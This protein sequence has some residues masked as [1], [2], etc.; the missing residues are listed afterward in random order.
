MIK[1]KR[2]QKLFVALTMMLLPLAASAQAT[3]SIE[4]FDIKAGEEKEMVI[5]LTNPNDEI[6]LVQFDLRLPAGLSLKQTGGDY[7]YDMCDRTTWRKHSLD[8][9]AT[10]GIIRFLLASSSNTVIS[11]STGA[12]I[13]MTLTA[14]GSFT[15]GTI[16]LENILLVS[17]DEKE[18]KPSDVEL[19]IGE[20]TP[21]GD[22]KDGDEFTA[23]TI[24]GIDMKFQV[25]SA[26]DKTCQ[27][28]IDDADDGE[29]SYA[30]VDRAIDFWE[31]RG[32]VTIPQTVNGFNVVKISEGAFVGCWYVTSIVIPEGVTTISLDAF[33]DCEG[34]EEINL[35]NSLRYI[36]DE[37]F[38]LCIS[39]K[40]VTIPANCSLGNYLF[41]SCQDLKSIHSYIQSPSDAGNA[42]EPHW[43]D[44]KVYENATL[45][46]PQGTKAKYQAA[47]GWKKFKNIVEEGETPT[48]VPDTSAY[49]SF[50]P[51]NIKAGETKE[52]VIDL[53]NP[54]DEITLV[55]FDLRLPTGLSLK[56]VGSDYDIDM[57]SRTT[58]RKHSLD[59]NET[60]GIIRFLLASSSNTVIDG[61]EGA[62]IKMTLV[63]D[64]SYSGG[65]V[66]LE[67]ILLVTPDE[68][69]IK[70][71][72][73]SGIE[74]IVTIAV[75][76][77]KSSKVYSLS[78]QRLAAPRKGINIVGGKKVLVK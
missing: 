78:G 24:E 60:D 59:A 72:N 48:P 28:G 64:G 3:L 56:K 10:E 37:A 12:I 16:R 5:D 8:V 41:D 14:D 40:N 47:E 45:Y 15:K 51:F 44:I 46:V 30:A 71:A 68:K 17:P 73:T 22:W 31:T 43:D 18:I 32:I 39:L 58:W 35:P 62:I 65:A 13:K 53:T 1:M 20:T 69:E 11:G 66:W 57:C 38:R 19:T 36:G 27:V 29:Y 74:H 52:M 23:K 26:K 4:N 70:P 9:N 55:Q 2:L 34:L 25:I 50:E 63:A 49:L 33:A 75:D 76:G 6:T 77:Q 54:E 21:S 7:K 42:F 67:N 61:T